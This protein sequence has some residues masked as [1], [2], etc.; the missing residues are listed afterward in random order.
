MSDIEHKIENSC[1]KHDFSAIHPFHHGKICKNCEVVG[2]GQKDCNNEA[3][4]HAE[5]E[6]Y[7]DQHYESVKL[8]K[9]GE[10]KKEVSECAGCGSKNGRC[11]NVVCKDCLAK[12]AKK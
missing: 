3:S 9:C 10:C 7:C 6:F 4:R 2:C 12:R 5:G 11:N 1:K 8:C